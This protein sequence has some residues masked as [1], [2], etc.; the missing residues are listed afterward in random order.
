MFAEISS[1]AKRARSL[2]GSFLKD[3]WVQIKN[4]FVF[5][6]YKNKNFNSK[7][8]SLFLKF[9][10]YSDRKIKRLLNKLLLANQ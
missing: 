7:K 5:S 6:K 10:V 4:L 8:I 9:I 1:A 3:K 2:L